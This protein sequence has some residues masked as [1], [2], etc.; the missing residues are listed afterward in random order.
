M[1]KG[2]RYSQIQN[3]IVNSI[4]NDKT[5]INTKFGVITFSDTALVGD[6]NYIDNPKDV[7]MKGNISASNLL[8]P[9]FSLTDLNSKDGFRQLFQTNKIITSESNHRNI[10]EALLLANDIYKC[11]GEENK[12]RAIIILTSGEMKYSVEA[13]KSIKEQQIKVITLDISD[14]KDNNIEKL[15]DQLGGNLNDY[16][17]EPLM[18]VIIIVWILI[19]QK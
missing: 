17:I 15:H 6:R 14:D 3:G 5:F 2:N 9:L 8:Q 10:N 18:V 7:S 12:N 4:I 11:F 19:W 13:I 1:N 16:I